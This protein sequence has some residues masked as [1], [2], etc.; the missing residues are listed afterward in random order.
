MARAETRLGL[1]RARSGVLLQQAVSVRAPAP[2]LA[3]QRD[4]VRALARQHALD[5]IAERGD[6]R[7]GHLA[8]R[9]PRVAEDPRI[10]VLIGADRVPDP[11]IGED[12]RENRHR[13][14]GARVLRVR[15]DPL[16]A[17][18]AR[19]RSTS[20]S[21]TKTADSPPTLSA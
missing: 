20:N 19:V 14:L 15:L 4:L 18:S 7:P 17:V 12:P 5:R 21:G 2:A 3:D 16:E 13:M 1:G 11:E 10:A 6:G 9:G 8:E